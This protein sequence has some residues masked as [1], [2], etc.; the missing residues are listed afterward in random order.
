MGDMERVIATH[1]HMGHQLD[2][3]ESVDDDDIT[4]RFVVDG[5]LLP[6]EAHPDRTPT[7]EE[8]VAL[9]ATFPEAHTTD[10]P[11]A[12][13]TNRSVLHPREIIA[14]L[15]ALDDEH[16]AHATYKQVIADFGQVLPFANIVESEARHIAALT[17]LMQRYEVPVPTNPW[18]GKVPRYES[19]AHACA[20]AVTAE[21]ENAALYERLLAA[22]DRPDIRAVLQNLQEASQQ[23]HLPAFQRCAQRGSHGEEHPVQR[24]HRRRGHK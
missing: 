23:R 6:V 1:H 11:P 18:P 4:I 19:L 21:I 13:A 5:E 22:T 3:V 17:E 15:D 12:Q 24:Q 10:A 7:D 14:L 2:V 20:D 16:K 9:L 8:A